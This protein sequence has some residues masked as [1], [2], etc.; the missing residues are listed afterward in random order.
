MISSLFFK[1]DDMMTI[2]CNKLSEAAYIYVAYLPNKSMIVAFV[3]SIKC[4]KTKSYQF[5]TSFDIVIL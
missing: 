4:I 3:A 2:T 5:F 1:L